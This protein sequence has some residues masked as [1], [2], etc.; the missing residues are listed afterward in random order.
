MLLLGTGAGAAWGRG[1]SP[2][3]PRSGTADAELQTRHFPSMTR[4]SPALNFVGLWGVGIVAGRGQVRG[5]LGTQPLCLVCSAPPQLHPKLSD[6]LVLP[7][8]EKE[9]KPQV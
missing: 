5:L 4:T 3:Q 6:P 7:I 9:R 8:L 1:E 2:G